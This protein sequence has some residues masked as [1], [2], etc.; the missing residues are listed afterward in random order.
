MHVCIHMFKI[1]L[2]NPDLTP[3]QEVIATFILQI[4]SYATLLENNNSKTTTGLADGP[5]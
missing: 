1:Y 4:K 3:F 5:G 2:L